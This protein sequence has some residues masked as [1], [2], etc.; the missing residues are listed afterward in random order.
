MT[1]T[2]R[3]SAYL[4]RLAADNAALHDEYEAVRI[5]KRDKAARDYAEMLKAKI[6]ERA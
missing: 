4:K 5:L 1:H 3:L 6:G 2:D